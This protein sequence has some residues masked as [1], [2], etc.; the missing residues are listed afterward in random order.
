MMIVPKHYEDLH[1]LHENT[2]PNRAYYI[3]ASRRLDGLEECREKS[4]RVQPLSLPLV[5][6][7]PGGPH[8][9][10]SARRPPGGLFHHPRPQLLA[11][12]GL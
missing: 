1:I 4:D 8:P 7:R 2:L 11:D 5:P 10:L 12:G 9:L 6:Q 3:P